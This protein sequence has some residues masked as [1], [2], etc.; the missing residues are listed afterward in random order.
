MKS[1]GRPSPPSE[2]LPN[3]E[4]E[5][6]VLPSTDRTP[7]DNK[8]SRMMRQAILHEMHR[9]P[10]DADE[11]AADKPQQV[12]RSLVG[13]AAQG[14]VSAIKEALEQI[15][16]KALPAVAESDDRFAG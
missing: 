13:K 4:S 5:R 3:L 7:D 16:E 11:P 10:G 12:A 14:D 15:D 8:A 6:T 9:P 2:S 1:P